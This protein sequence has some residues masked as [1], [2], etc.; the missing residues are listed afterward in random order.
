MYMQNQKTLWK[1]TLIHPKTLIN[2]STTFVQEKVLT[3]TFYI[4]KSSQFLSTNKKIIIFSHVQNSRKENFI[5]Q[6][7]PNI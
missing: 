5:W 3:K 7:D 2:F 1:I 6:I 4:I